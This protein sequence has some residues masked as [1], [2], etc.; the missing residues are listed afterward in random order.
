MFNEWMAA[1]NRFSGCRS[2]EYKQRQ[3]SVSAIQPATQQD[4]APAMPPHKIGSLKTSNPFSGCLLLGKII[5]L[6]RVRSL[7]WRFSPR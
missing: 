5:G 1:L 7:V 3:T 6:R 4:N 2:N